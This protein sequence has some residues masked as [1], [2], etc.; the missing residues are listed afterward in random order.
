MILESLPTPWY[1]LTAIAAGALLAVLT[2]GLYAF[3]GWEIIAAVYG[4]PAIVYFLYKLAE[5]QRNNVTPE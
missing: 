4:V 5:K 1:E 3:F 2:I